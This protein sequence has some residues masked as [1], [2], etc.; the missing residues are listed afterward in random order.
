MRSPGFKFCFHVQLVY[1]YIENRG[2]YVHLMA[3]HLLHAQLRRQS[4]AFVAGF[5]SLVPPEWLHVFAPAE[6]RWGSLH[7]GIKL[8]H[9]S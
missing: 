3:H 5:R 8:T 6:L 9:N 2:R 1:R 7:V 4:N